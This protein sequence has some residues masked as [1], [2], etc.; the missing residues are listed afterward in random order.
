MTEQTKMSENGWIVAEIESME[1]NKQGNFESLPSMKFTEN[2]VT[3][4]SID[5]SKP[6]QK[7][8][9]QNT[10]GKTVN[11]AIIPVTHN[12]E[13]K[14]WWL[15]IQNPTY[16]DVM[17]LG[18]EGKNTIKILQTGTKQNTKYVVIK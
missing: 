6:F 13:K 7:W 8:T 9:G 4:L 10:N 3:E 5:F 1:Q 12:G 11:K 16:K 15:N 2:E 17:H 14:N 18:K